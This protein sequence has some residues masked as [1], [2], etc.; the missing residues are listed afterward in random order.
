MGS[1]FSCFLFSIDDSLQ[2]VVVDIKCAKLV[3]WS[4]TSVYIYLPNQ[5][6]LDLPTSANRHESSENN[7]YFIIY[8]KSNPPWHKQFQALEG[9]YILTRSIGKPRCIQQRPE[10]ACRGKKCFPSYLHPRRRKTPRFRINNCTYDVFTACLTFYLYAV[11]LFFARFVYGFFLILFFF[12]YDRATIYASGR[13]SRYQEKW[14]YMEKKNFF[15][16]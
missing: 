14:A 4:Y 12:K 15:R 6:L 3:N 1:I 9:I 2:C 13:V 5:L 7:L 8:T 10:G 11:C 16:E